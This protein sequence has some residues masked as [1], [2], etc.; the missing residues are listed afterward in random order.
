MR[1]DNLVVLAVNFDG[2]PIAQSLRDAWEAAK[3]PSFLTLVWKSTAEYDNP[4]AVL[5]AVCRGEYWAAIYTTAGASHRLSDALLGGSAAATYQA[6]DA[7][8]YVWNQA[9]YPTVSEG[10]ISTQ[11][12]Q[13]IELSRSKACVAYK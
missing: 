4:S 11:L 8:Q 7:M 9:R 12:G 6:S 2:G 10:V 5:E 13:L 3:S 1:N